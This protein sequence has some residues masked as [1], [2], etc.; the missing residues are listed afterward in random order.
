MRARTLRSALLGLSCLVAVVAVAACSGGGGGGG[1]G[2]SGQFLLAIGDS[3]LV[4]DGNGTA[5]TTVFVARAD[6]EGPVSIHLGPNA[7]TGL[8]IDPLVIAEGSTAGSLVFHKGASTPL[9]GP[10]RF[11]IVGSGNNG[12]VDD[13]LIDLLVTGPSGALDATFGSGGAVAITFAGPAS[14]EGAVEMADDSVVLGGWA[15]GD[16]AL[17]R[18]E[19]DG[20]PFTGFGSNGTATLDF[21]GGDD[22]AFALLRQVDGKLVLAGSAEESGGGFTMAMARFTADGELDTDFGTGGKVTIPAAGDEGVL[23]SIVQQDDGMLLGGGSALV[24]T[25][26]TL[27]L[28]RFDASGA[29]DPTFGGGDGIVHRPLGDGHSAALDVTVRIDGLIIASGH[30]MDEDEQRWTVAYFDV[31]GSALGPV[32]TGEVTGGEAHAVAWTFEGFLAA[33]TQGAGADEAFVAGLGLDGLTDNAF[34]GGDGIVSFPGTAVDMGVQ[35]DGRVVIGGESAGD[36]FVCRTTPLGDVDPTW[37]TA[38]M[39]TADLGAPD[40]TVR[41]IHVS[42]DTRIFALGESDGRMAIARFWP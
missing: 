42:R 39:V 7:P 26:L 31:D 12:L 19:A 14:A 36:F 16:F 33:G 29:P 8:T 4:T 38:G 11:A 23:H 2:S 40:D 34:G 3:D 21:E 5:Q 41:A 10:T 35:A 9:G 22:R 1:G 13:A 24:G 28:V 32:E 27:T 20:V 18:V 6:Y 17:A 15:D 37:G 30:S 25:T